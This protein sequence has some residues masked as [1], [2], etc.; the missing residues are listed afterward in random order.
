MD[1]HIR[2]HECEKFLC[3]LSS[4]HNIKTKDE[5]KL[6]KFIEALWFMA[7]TGCQ[8]RLCPPNYGAWRSVHQCFMRWNRKNIGNILFEECLDPDLQ[9]MMMD[10][11]SIRAHACAEGYGKNTQ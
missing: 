4:I 11:T 9:E 7:R 10:G 1:Y 6:R 8:W 2:T 5:L 3:I